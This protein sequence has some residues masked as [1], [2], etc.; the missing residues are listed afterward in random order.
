MLPEIGDLIS[1]CFYRD[2]L[3]SVGRP[4]DPLLAS[5]LPKAVTWKSTS[6]MPKRASS[7]VGTSHFNNLEV[8]L[9]ESL[10][11]RLDFDIQ[12]GKWKDRTCSVAVLTGYGEQ[13]RRLQ[14]SIDVRRQ[15]WKSFSHIF[16]N[17]VDAFQGREADVA[18]FSVT[19]SDVSGLG[20]LR[21]MERINVALSRGKERL[22]IVGD[23]SYC[24]QAPDVENPLKEVISYIE[25]NPS[26]CTIE[27]VQP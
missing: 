5:A 26:S 23:H 8:Q 13:K 21:E 4:P 11:A 19:R 6:R 7:K 18:I 10:L 24:L 20:F 14:T 2:E 22:I 15:G 16:V 1:H 17:V 25:R 3:T 27:V 12:H 9:I